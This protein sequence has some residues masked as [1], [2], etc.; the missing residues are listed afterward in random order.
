MVSGALRRSEGDAQT[1]D[2]RSARRSEADVPG[3]DVT[4]VYNEL[5]EEQTQQAILIATDAL[6]Q[7]HT[8]KVEHFKDVA[9][10]IKV[11]FEAKYGPCWHVICGKD[12]GSH[13]THEVRNIFFCTMGR[14]SVLIFKHG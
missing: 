4:M 9:K 5:P 3:G 6:R 13:V 12:F 7:M 11:E 8:G 1:R 2:S 14:T 10:I